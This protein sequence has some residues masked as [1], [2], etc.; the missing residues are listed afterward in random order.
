MKIRYSDIYQPVMWH[1]DVSLATTVLVLLVIIIG[2]G[3]YAKFNQNSVK[4]RRLLKFDHFTE[5]EKE[6]LSDSHF[7]I[8]KQETMRIDQKLMQ[9]DQT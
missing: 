4:V 8:L 1:D 3:F 5:F 7:Q 2:S 9:V 6:K